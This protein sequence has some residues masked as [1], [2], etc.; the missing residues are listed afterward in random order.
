MK[1]FLCHL[2]L[3]CIE[4]SIL[5]G[6][7]QFLSFFFVSFR[8]R[9]L[10]SDDCLEIQRDLSTILTAIT[11]PKEIQKRYAILFSKYYKFDMK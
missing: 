7:R 4:S 10:L 8:I 11:F 1:I 3:S 9:R 2:I 6:L 5:L